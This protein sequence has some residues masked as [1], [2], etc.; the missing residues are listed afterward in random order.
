MEGK[1]IRTEFLVFG[2]V[3]H[4]VLDRL[5][6]LPLHVLEPADILP[7]HIRHLHLG[8]SEG[9]GVADGHGVPEVLVGDHK[10]IEELRVDLLVVN[11]NIAGGGRE[12][13]RE[14]GRM[15]GKNLREKM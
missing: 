5:G 8:L 6:Q 13:G 15:G 4:R 10:G 7:R 9:G 14:G 1:Q 11:V 12:G 3:L 2:C